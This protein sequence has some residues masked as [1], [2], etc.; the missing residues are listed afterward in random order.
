ENRAHSRFNRACES[1][2]RQ[3]RGFCLARS[4]RSVNSGSQMK[5]WVVRSC[6]K[7]E[8]YKNEEATC[9]ICF[10]VLS[11]TLNTLSCRHIFHNQVTKPSIG[12]WLRNYH[13]NK[14]ELRLKNEE[15]AFKKLARIKFFIT[16]AVIAYATTEW[17]IAMIACF[18]KEEC[19]EPL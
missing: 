16:N 12:I 1:D 6:K 10:G 13:G 3:M 11:D 9:Q 14:W 19:Y 7:F 17:V 15:R 2:H 8:G 5:G 4:C 18:L